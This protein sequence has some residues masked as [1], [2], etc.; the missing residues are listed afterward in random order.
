MSSSSGTADGLRVIPNDF[1]GFTTSAT[2]A[3]DRLV[4]L[5]RQ[6]SDGT[7]IEFRKANSTVGSIGVEGGDN[8]YITDNNNTGLNMKS[9]LIIPCNTN[10]STRGDAID[11]GANGG[12]FKDLWLSGG[13]YLGGTGSA[14]H[15]DD[16]EEGTWTPT[17]GSNVAALSG[18][19]G[20][21]TKVGNLVTITFEV[22]ADP[23][24]TTSNMQFGGLPFTVINHL[25]STNVG[26]TG[27]AYE[28]N[29]FF[30]FWVQETANTFVIELDRPLQGSAS[31][32]SKNYRGT[33][34]YFTS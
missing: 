15:L 3:G 22:N 33:L 4:L 25:S 31:S 17:G 14:N 26:A 13:V 21:Y 18:A 6:A 28:D 8:F 30:G 23:T 7:H 10:G 32:I 27:I 1:L 19:N 12:R 20:H 5:N 11:L 2:D 24:S 16:Y 9:G 29:S 34:T